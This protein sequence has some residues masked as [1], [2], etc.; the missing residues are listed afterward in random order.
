MFNKRRARR[1]RRISRKNSK[2]E[3]RKLFKISKFLF[4]KKHQPKPNKRKARILKRIKT[5][6]RN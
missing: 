6:F 5:K 1:E 4:C 2:R 3:K